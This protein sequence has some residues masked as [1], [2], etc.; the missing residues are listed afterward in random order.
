MVNAFGSIINGLIASGPVQEEGDAV[1]NGIRIC[2]KCMA[3]KQAHVEILGEM[4]LVPVLC[5]CQTAERNRREEE[6]R[7]AREIERRERMRRNGITNAEWQNATFADDDGRDADSGTKCR[8]YVKNFATMAETNVGLMLYG[9]VG[10]GKT[11][12][13]GCIANALIEQDYSVLM[14]SLPGLIAEVNADF[15]ENREKI[16]DRIERCGLLILDD[17]G[18]ERSTEYSIEQSYEIINARYKSGK[19]LVITTNLTPQDLTAPAL[20]R[21]RMYDRLIEM[22]APVLV[23]GR[24]RRVEIANEKRAA[25]MRMLEGL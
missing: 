6:Y 18:V 20:D 22:C 14:A 10:C 13:A 11:F 24:S 23:K 5:D 19:P 15:C 12:L 21:R 3:P 8:N 9:D 16:M 2:G 25:A 7:K 17:V 1:V 4:R